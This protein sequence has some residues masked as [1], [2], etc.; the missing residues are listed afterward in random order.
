M[1]ETIETTDE[2]EDETLN[3]LK[4]ERHLLECYVTRVRTRRKKD[5][6]D[7]DNSLKDEIKYYAKF[8]CGPFNETPIVIDFNWMRYLHVDEVLN[9]IYSNLLAFRSPYFIDKS[10]CKIEKKIE[11]M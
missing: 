3:I 9:L 7:E 11:M 4:E 10:S 8:W 1:G 2:F 6:H 5:E